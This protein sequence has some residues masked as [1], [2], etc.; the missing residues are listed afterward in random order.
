M[1][2]NE[3]LAAVNRAVGAYAPHISRK[4]VTGN[5]D[6]DSL[7][8]EKRSLY[9]ASTHEGRKGPT[10]IRSSSG[11][12]KLSKLS[13][14]RSWNSSTPNVSS[15]SIV[16]PLNPTAAAPLWKEQV[17]PNIKA[18]LPQAEIHRQ[19]VMFEIIR[20]EK[21]FV[22]D[23]KYLIEH[24]VN[25][26]QDSGIRLPS[27]LEQ[28][29][30]ILPDI[31][32]LHL[33]ASL[34]L[35]CT[36]AIMYPVIP[37]I[38]HILRD[39]SKHFHLYEKYLINYQTA[40]SEIANARK[41]NNKLGQLVKSLESGLLPGRYLALESLLT[42]PF[43]R[44]C[45]Y[46]LLVMNLLRATAPDHKDHSSLV[47]LHDQIDCALKELQERKSRYERLKENDDFSRKLTTLGPFNKLYSTYRYKRSVTMPFA[48]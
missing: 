13:M 10:I 43:Q 15:T 47:D 6:T 40:I 36:Q 25:K 41:K 38:T 34:Q 3:L 37:S 14:K 5:D 42:K 22:E 21:A 30:S 46:P 28:T 11:F 31:L 35:R 7:L 45:K 44:L 39:L 32:L 26:F 19:E 48:R 24:Y 2:F 20:T 23:T 8:D 12:L 16:T 33:N 29:F 9:C 1:S 17:D 4:A 27:S 18:E